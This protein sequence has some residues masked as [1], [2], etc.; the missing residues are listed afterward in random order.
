MGG[1]RQ[2]GRSPQPG[3]GD[4][5]SGCRPAAP[6]RSRTIPPVG[7]AFPRPAG[8]ESLV[9]PEGSGM[10]LSDGHVVGRRRTLPVLTL[11]C[12]GYGAVRVNFPADIH[13]NGS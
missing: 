12:D 11:N 9:A 4:E 7:V 1:L 3:A 2:R 8:G 6:A 10:D 13:A 5:N